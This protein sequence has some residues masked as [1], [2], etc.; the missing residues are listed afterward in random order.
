MFGAAA[1]QPPQPQK[2]QREH[3]RLALELPINVMS[4]SVAVPVPATLNDVSEGGA[5]ITAQIMLLRGSAVEFD[6]P[7]GEG[8]KPVK[9]Q[10]AI[11]SI[12]FK[13][14]NRTF[15]Y[16]IQF[17]TMRQA[18]RDVVYA[19]IV[20]HQ[21]RGIQSKLEP[22]VSKQNSLELHS[23]RER[24]AYR[25]DRSF[26]VRYSVLGQRGS[27]PATALDVSRGG[28]RLVADRAL[29]TDQDLEVR[30]TLPSDVLTVLARREVTRSGSIFGRELE[31]KEIKPPT[32]EE[33]HCQVK[34][35]TSTQEKGKFI[36]S[37]TFVR[38]TDHFSEEIQRFVHA[39]QLSELQR[40]RGKATGLRVI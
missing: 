36:Y 31:M 25:V 30:F 1:A 6:L 15:I 33:M 16:G 5:R 38:P 11:T 14:S 21:R 8:S 37:V 24:G 4:P 39:S 29:R 23:V 13:Q 17:K 28:M 19:F 2:N 27:T 34:L 3:F 18:D 10:G 12:N 40:Q 35:L 20:E 9:L 26:A 7:R 32:F 22:P